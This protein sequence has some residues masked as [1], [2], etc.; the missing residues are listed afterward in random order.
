MNNNN[1]EGFKIQNI[2]KNAR[3]KSEFSLVFVMFVTLIFTYFSYPFR[4][5]FI[6]VYVG[7]SE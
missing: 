7:Q 3:E 5:L 4:N 1:F 2:I 6:L